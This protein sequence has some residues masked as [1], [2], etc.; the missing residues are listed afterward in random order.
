MRTFARE[1]RLLKTLAHP[2]RIAILAVLRNN[3]ACACHVGAVLGRSQAYVSQQIA[4]LREAG[5]VEGRHSGTYVYYRIRDHAVLGLVD[6]ATRMAGLPAAAAL[7][8]ERC[9]C[10]QCRAA[11]TGRACA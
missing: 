1:S 5:L 6:L 7:E 9:R 8:P 11:S 3:E 10:P 4:I 2:E